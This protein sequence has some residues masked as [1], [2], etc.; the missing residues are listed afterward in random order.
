MEATALCVDE[1]PVASETVLRVTIA[2]CSD[3]EIVKE[4]ECFGASTSATR[5]PWSNEAAHNCFW[6]LG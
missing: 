3:K 6:Y 4:I 5:D 1:A 2:H